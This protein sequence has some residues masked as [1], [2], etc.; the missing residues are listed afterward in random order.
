MAGVGG[1]LLS[2]KSVNVIG[3]IAST[4]LWDGR[5]GPDRCCMKLSHVK[6]NRLLNEMICFVCCC[7]PSDPDPVVAARFVEL[8]Y[9]LII[10]DNYMIC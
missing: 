8:N 2:E 1:S 7:S 9:K 4:T 5:D 3:G 6:L 10:V